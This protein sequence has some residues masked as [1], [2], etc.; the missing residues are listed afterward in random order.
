MPT[1]VEWAEMRPELARLWN[2]GLSGAE[3]ARRLDPSGRITRNAVL[4]Q[5]HRHRLGARP[6]QIARPPRASRRRRIGI[7]PAPRIVYPVG[8]P[9]TPVA[10]ARGLRLTDD[11]FGGCRWPTEAAP[12]GEGFNTVFCCAPRD[13]RATYC[14][15]HAARARHPRQ[16]KGPPT[17]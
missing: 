16:P 3:I 4:G 12:V 6:P 1:W 9:E 15:A 7:A 2:D 13:P 17:P 10:G 14:P 11:A 8:P 5:I